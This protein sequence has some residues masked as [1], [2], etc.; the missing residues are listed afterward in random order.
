MQDSK[1]MERALRAIRASELIVKQYTN[2]LTDEE[3]A[4]LNSWIGESPENLKLYN[5]MV[6]KGHM[7]KDMD[8][9]SQYD[10]LVG[11][12]NLLDKINNEQDG[13][14]Q[15]DLETL[16]Q[17]FQQGSYS[18]PRVVPVNFFRRYAAAAILIVVIGASMF[19]Y[20]K[21]NVASRN[22]DKPIFTQLSPK[23]ILPGSKKARLVLA[24]G[25]IVE[26]D[27]ADSTFS[28]ES[29]TQVTVNKGTVAY[30]GATGNNEA[31]YHTLIVPRGAEY[32][33]W[34]DD[35]TRVWLNAS[36]SLHY[37]AKFT[38]N[39]RTVMLTGEGYF[40][41]AEDKSRPFHVSVNN[42]DVKVTGTE[43]NINS[44]SDEAIVRA[45]LFKGGVHITGAKISFD[46]KPGQQLQTN[47]NGQA[48]VVN[49]DLEATAAWKNGVFSLSGADVPTIMRQILRWYDLEQVVYPANFDSQS[50]HISG[51]FPKNAT[52]DEVLEVLAINGVHFRL[53]NKK[54]IMLSK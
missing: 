24:D 10:V 18:A 49:A 52:L 40:Q 23:D 29:G 2:D 6:H 50:I 47:A 48:K 7:R 31:A 25:Q 44:Y 20:W 53:D 28:T 41:V 4:E 8:A 15:L 35:G 46:L 3:L 27:K 22:D 32:A 36:S 38:G 21:N 54:L 43:F 11:H 51:T 19:W 12:R 37:P 17:D 13:Q 5:E 39:E 26:I 16:H 45:T 34:L 30:K 9:L 1:K 42:L 14:D 33:L